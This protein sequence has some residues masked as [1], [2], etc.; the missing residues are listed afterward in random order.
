MEKQSLLEFFKK[1]KVLSIGLIVV[2]AILF[3]DGYILKP[4]RKAKEI[5]QQRGNSVNRTNTQQNTPVSNNMNMAQSN[6]SEIRPPDPFVRV[7]FPELSSKLDERFSTNINYPFSKGRNVFTE[8]EKPVL[9]VEAIQEA[10]EE[11]IE[12]PDISYHG[13]FTLGNDK[14]AILKKSDEVLLTKVGTKV[15]RT[16]F[17]LASI[18]PEKVTMT[19]MANRLRDFEISLA[20]E[21]ESN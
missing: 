17:K 19:D 7:T 18:S 11:V 5:G 15:R 10:V 6:P 20:D 8:I 9:I 13:F 2:L 12:K 21:T 3:V 4:M 1:N 16:S 14:V